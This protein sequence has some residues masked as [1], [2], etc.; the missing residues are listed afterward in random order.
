MSGSSVQRESPP[1]A[2]DDA[3]D[4]LLADFEEVTARLLFVP[5]QGPG[6][7]SAH[8]MVTQ[9]AR[10][11]HMVGR[12]RGDG[13]PPY[14]FY[15]DAYGYRTIEAETNVNEVHS[16]SRFDPKDKLYRMQWTPHSFYRWCGYL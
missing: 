2:I 5:S 7:V 11:V 8:P 9:E 6:I 16:L 15:E 4:P 3:D 1:T 13:L 10:Q 14:A 12:H